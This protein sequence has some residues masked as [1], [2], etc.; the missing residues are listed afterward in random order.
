M[1]LFL[2]YLLIILSLNAQELIDE[3]LVVVG[4][5]IITKSDLD[6]SILFLKSQ[7]RATDAQLQK[8]KPLILEKLIESKLLYIQAQ[9]DSVIVAPERLEEVAEQRWRELVQRF[10]SERRMEDYFNEPIKDIR[11]RQMEDLEEQLTIM[12]LQNE[13]SQNINISRAEV[14]TFFNTYKDSLPNRPERVELARILINIEASDEARKRAYNKAKEAIKELNNGIDFAELAKKT[15]EGPSA[16][17]GGYLGL[18]DVNGYVPE[19][20][21]AALSMSKKGEI[22]IEP[23]L[24]QFGYHIIKYHSNEDADKYELSHI[25]FLVKE[26]EDDLKRAEL[27]LD[28]ARTEIVNGN[29]T[30]DEAAAK[31]NKNDIER[32]KKG[33][34]GILD[35][36]QIKDQNLVRQIK[37]MYDGEISKPFKDPEG[38]QIIKLIK[39]YESDKFNFKRDYSYIE[40]MAKKQKDDK[41]FREFVAKIKSEIPY[42]MNGSIAFDE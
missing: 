13:F 32:E 31:F 3:I 6:Q 41:A 8:Q 34:I 19:F 12:Q 38:L 4:D 40:Q 35:I 29:I 20:R 39:H 22:S 7:N 2:S 17:N 25:L 21:D 42:N 26:T 10:G 11:K 36:N 33:Y 24:T 37:F 15:S 1:K 5:E 9:L 30:F 18:S 27:F 16:K 14:E 23:V 28:S